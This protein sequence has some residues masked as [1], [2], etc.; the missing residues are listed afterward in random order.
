MSGKATTSD[1][2]LQS[3][4]N[5]IQ[6]TGP[7]NVVELLNDETIIHKKK[8]K[9]AK[10]EK[11]GED[12]SKKHKK[13][14][15]DK[16]KSKNKDIEDEMEHKK[17]KK[18]KDKKKEADGL[19]VEKVKK[20]KKSKTELE[21]NVKPEK[22]V[23]EW[24]V[25]KTES[26]F[27]R[28]DRRSERDISPI[29]TKQR[30]LS[31]HSFLRNSRRTTPP[32]KNFNRNSRIS[33]SPIRNGRRSISPDR[34]KR[35]SPERVSTLRSPDFRYR[36]D[37]YQSRR[38][39]FGFARNSRSRSRSWSP[40]RFQRRRSPKREV[41]LEDMKINKEELLEIAER[42]AYRLAM[43]G[44]L[45]K[46][47]DI[48]A[49]LQKKS[50]KE[51]IKYCEEIKSKKFNLPL[52]ESLVEETDKDFDFTTLPVR[53]AIKLNV[54]TSMKPK[55]ALERLI[56]ESA[57]RKAFPVSSGEEYSDA[58]DWQLV[59]V[60]HS[61][62]TA[63]SSKK[64]K[65]A[66]AYLFSDPPPPAPVPPP[67]KMTKPLHPVPPLIVDPILDWSIL[68]PPPPPFTCA[69]FDA[70][71]ITKEMPALP[72]VISDYGELLTEEER[73]EVLEGPLPEEPVPMEI[74]EGEIVPPPSRWEP[75]SLAGFVP[76]K[77]KKKE[78]D[79]DK[80]NNKEDDKKDE[81]KTKKKKEKAK[82]ERSEASNSDKDGKPGS[83]QDN[84]KEGTKDDD[85]E[86]EKAED[87]EGVIRRT[88]D[89][90]IL[91]IEKESTSYSNIAFTL[92]KDELEMLDE[93]LDQDEAQ[94]DQKLV[95]YDDED[96]S[97]ESSGSDSEEEGA[98]LMCENDNEKIIGI[99]ESV[100]G[101]FLETPNFS[102]DIS[103]MPVVAP[104][105]CGHLV[106]ERVRLQQYLN[107]NP[108]D[109]AAKM[110]VADVELKLS[111]WA[112]SK[113]KDAARFGVA[114]IM[115]A[116]MEVRVTQNSVWATKDTLRNAPQLTT[117]IGAHL[118]QKM[119]WVPGLG[120][121]R[122]M[123]GPVEPLILDVKSDRKGLYSTVQDVKPPK[124]EKIAN[125]NGK[126]PV[127][128]IMEHC[129]KNGLPPPYFDQYDEGSEHRKRFGCKAV[130]NGVEY[131]A[132]CAS[133]NKKA[134]KAQVCLIM[135]RALG[136]GCSE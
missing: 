61:V 32:Y 94:K 130:L 20:K 91:Q 117:G 57:L 127:S 26:S 125:L 36:N 43:A 81:G 105:K 99:G 136:L 29:R 65:V 60:E 135:C 101:S 118:L 46:N 9:K 79:N 62:I 109:F 10:K 76:V 115:D 84:E 5:D 103:M 37:R 120:L 72:K 90:I 48:S 83:S 134:A 22:R 121:G 41:K 52:N 64:V 78:A 95:D 75:M 71:A 8:E 13:K 58:T 87:T 19:D 128:V 7:V 110:A 24:D 45:P 27:G 56:E 16:K 77:R 132:A 1:E 18:H 33:I 2:L 47:Y 49:S 38:S 113:E 21:E 68:Q 59:P 11:D 42:N 70:P 124:R 17:E 86:V 80:E 122:K 69:A 34:R 96:S 82:K 111:R 31:P 88:L 53:P 30:R 98:T 108:N 107:E 23:R 119:G 92:D 4:F 50:I 93:M 51:L 114:P 67:L 14:D 25:G 126:N 102:S 116:N 74:E 39:G 106:A 89:Y 12:D 131:N 112:E 54:G 3:L 97:G 73:R 104:V 55:S 28:G 35:R 129:S 44:K 15:K 40:R 63:L 133:T 6:K 85:K 100:F 66:P 123:N